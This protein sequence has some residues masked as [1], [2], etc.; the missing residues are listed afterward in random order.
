MPAPDL[1]QILK[2]LA[3]GTL[4]PADGD[5]LHRAL[6]EGHLL[7][8]T[9]DRAV[10]L[11]GSA[12]GAV[13]TTGDN[14]I[15]VRLDA[16]RRADLEK[17]LAS[18]LHNVPLL[19]DHYIPRETFLA[20][21]R[22]VLLRDGAPTLGIVGVQGMG[23]IGKSVLAAALAR[24]LTVRA[25][26]PDGV[27]WLA[28]GR[29]PNLTARQEDLYLLLTGERE[30]F[31]DPAQ[32]R[33]FLAPALQ[34]KT[35][36]VILDDLWELEHAEAFPLRL[37]GA[38]A[39]FLITT[40]NG[41]LLQT[42]QAKP[43]LLEELT[44]DQALHLLAEWAGQEV[45]SLPPTACEVARECGYLPLALAMVGAFVRQNPES[46][47]RALHRLQKADLEKLRCLFP[48]Y[49]HSTL[50]A[51]LEVSVAALPKDAR[52][53]YLDLAV[54]PE[55][56]AIPLDVLRAFWG[57]DADDVADLAETFVGRSLARW[58][59]TGRSLRL[60]DLQHDY[61]HAV[62]RDTLPDL[63][64]RFLLA[65]ARSLLG[66]DGQTLDGMPWQ[67]LPAEPRYLW[68]RLVYHLLEAGAWEA[69]Y[70]LLTDF[71]YLEARCRATSVFD[72]EADYRL[73][74]TRWPENDADRCAVLA[75]FEERLRLEDYHIA[76]APEWLFPALY[77]HLTWPDAPEGPLHALCEAARPRRRNWLR[78]LQ[79]P[80]PQPP[81]WLRSLEGHTD[82][83]ECGGA[84]RRWALHRQRVERP[85][86]EGVGAGDGAPA[87]LAGRACEGGDCGGAERGWALGRQR[88]ERQDGEGVGAGDG[89]P[90][91]LFGRTYGYC[92]CG[93][94]E[95]G[96]ALGRQRVERQ[97][98]EGVGAGDGAPTA[99]FGR[100]YECGDC[101]GAE[102]G[103]ALGRQRARTTRR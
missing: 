103:W 44:P 14:N 90:A 88:V 80:R 72:L 12:D 79:D 58:E 71:D 9:G 62:Q 36:L 6:T 33:L 23:G 34:E 29:E 94:A 42:L 91:A 7:I 83:G 84:E 48:G 69:L 98:G 37:E 4:S 92:D 65:C 39:R 18:H 61:L 96:W 53:R 13:I 99:L 32:G 3:E 10:A 2:R 81:P 51:A 35:C 66:V 31:K 16:R 63:H 74:L 20:P 17:L 1:E 27:I 86:G 26:F 100:T 30:N 43:F 101:G 97:D 64:C 8:A 70:R 28:L 50:L 87:A 25:A 52:A 67:R 89:A 45:S 19:P 41:E 54:F 11:G 49:K 68:D 24:D 57:L 40:R 73:A 15:I 60:H 38:R 22:D 82:N 55:E 5:L 102:R 56:E 47:E 46:W 85:H 77:N 75:A 78:S 93:G 76:A 21:L 95:R 59:E